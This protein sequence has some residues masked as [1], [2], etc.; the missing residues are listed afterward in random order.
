M[1][2]VEI[3]L[4]PKLIPVF[5]GKARYRG[6]YGGRGSAKSHTFA[7][8]AAIHGAY[9]PMTIVCV[10]EMLNSIKDSVHREIVTAI[11][12]YPWLQ[13]AYDYGESYIRGHN[14][15]EFI[16]KGLKNN[17]KEIK[18][19]AKVDLCWIEEAEGV[20]EE[21]YRILLPTIRNPDSEIWLTWNRESKSS[22][23]NQR[24]IV[25]P[26]ESA[27]IVEINYK[28][29][30]WFPQVLEELRQED[31]KRLSK[32]MY[33]HV[34]EG[35]YLEFKENRVLANWSSANE[36]ETL[37][38]DPDR[39]IYMTCDFNHNPISFVFAHISVDERGKREYEFFDE[40]VYGSTTTAQ[41]AEIVGQRYANH[42]AGILVTGDFSGQSRTSKGRSDYKDIE[43][44][45]LGWGI[46]NV[47]IQPL[48]SNP[49]KSD[50]HQL[51]ISKVKT[52]EGFNYIKINPKTCPN[53]HHVLTNMEWVTGGEGFEIKD[54]TA[55]QIE[56]DASGKLKYFF[57]PYDAVSYLV[58][59]FD[60]KREAKA[61]SGQVYKDIPYRPSRA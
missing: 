22:A 31:F 20:S 39:R 21:S 26:P 1:N 11:E 46:P 57:H 36:D 49:I 23:T 18:S 61:K 51:F 56:R 34:W 29:N 55:Q 4:P 16:F 12:R 2:E 60:G 52:A 17:V 58:C 10:R 54:Y 27:K 53:T 33:E 42:Q 25:N 45:L 50:R 8:M 24:F 28:D 3:E 19:L 40:L 43:E 32:E 7:L 5:D 37:A 59:K 47:V 48:K 35:K 38:Y 41:A 9:R 30:P 6:A 44:A 14:G 15:T 13:S